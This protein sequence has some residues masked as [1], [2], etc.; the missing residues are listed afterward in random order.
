MRGLREKEKL[1]AIFQ[2]I[3]DKHLDIV[4][5]QDTH[6][7][8]ETLEIWSE[9]W[10]RNSGGGDS[11]WHSGNS[12]QGGV[13]L[14]TKPGLK[15]EVTDKDANG[16]ILFANIFKNEQITLR[17]SSLYAPTSKFP[18]EQLTF[19]K[20]LIEFDEKN[21]G[22]TYHGGDLNTYLTN[23]DS[24]NFDKRTK[25]GKD[26]AEWIEKNNIIDVYRVAN[27]NTRV[28]TWQNKKSKSRI[29]YW[30]C[31]DTLA[32]NI[33]NAK[34]IPAVKT[35]HKLITL[36]II[37][38]F[39]SWG[40]GL[41]KLNTSLLRDKIYVDEVKSIIEQGKIKYKNNN[42]LNMWDTIKM[43]IRLF[44][45]SYS[46]RKKKE[47]NKQKS[48]LTKTLSDLEKEGKEMDEQYQSAQ[49][50]LDNIYIHEAKGKLLQLKIEDT[51]DDFANQQ[52]INMFKNKTKPNIK[53]LTDENNKDLTDKK[54]LKDHVT[55]FYKKLYTKKSVTT[56]KDQIKFISN[57]KGLK[58]LSSEDKEKLENLISELEI[59]KAIKDL[60][61]G[62]SPGIDGFP[63]DF[64]KFFWLDIKE[65]IV[66]LIRENQ[67]ENRL[68]IDQKRA[69]LSL[70][71]KGNKNHKFLKNW[72]PISLLCTHYKIFTKV[73]ANRINPLLDKIISVHQNAYIK[74]RLISN[75][76]RTIQDIIEHYKSENPGI[77]SIL[78]FEKAFDVVDWNF[79][80][81]TLLAMNFGNGIINSIFTTLNKE[82]ETGILL[83]GE[84]TSFFGPTRGLRQGDPLSGLLFLLVAETL[85]QTILENDKIEGIKI[86]E[87]E[88]KID[89]FADDTRLFLKNKKSLKYALEV[90]DQ[91][92]KVTGL[93][94]NRDKSESFWVGGKQLSDKPFGLKW[95]SDPIK[96]LGVWV[97]NN[98]DVMNKL[99]RKEILDRINKNVKIYKNIKMNLS[100]KIYILNT[101]LLSQVNFIAT[102]ILMNKETISLIKKEFLD[103]V[104]DRKPP[105]IKY[106][107]VIGDLKEGGIRLVDIENKIKA[108]QTT[109]VRNCKGGATV[110]KNFS[111]NK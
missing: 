42:F 78:D 10:K 83:N 46:S 79:L 3:L 103:F 29:D 28:F 87:Y 2:Y 82:I 45:I 4:A 102:S 25:Y 9:I 18:N 56:I 65:L 26:L 15:I 73:L 31:D 70:L 35:D 50:E 71:P 108:L 13:A 55:K 59:L 62:K 5:V 48:D 57:I 76:L 111:T 68:S 81:Q 74:G 107:T 106:N 61:N 92:H 34:I 75:N 91:F 84:L 37:D 93:K 43:D 20:N 58:K 33:S 14:L 89:Q 60:P 44:T 99:N 63:I 105:K 109:W 40:R 98:I 85:S 80:K 101:K 27:P 77:I 38:E 49:K 90:L 52:L 19:L 100:S 64:Y 32:P 22:E 96:S 47:R 36:D 72:R 88:Q 53:V 30:L 23:L 51:L 110:A 67:I 97:C 1:V 69:V 12:Y 16:R 95:T 24:Q 104:W 94:V 11:Y 8:E 17:V 7:T 6:S 39:S 41:W 21:P 54:G 66:G 86:G